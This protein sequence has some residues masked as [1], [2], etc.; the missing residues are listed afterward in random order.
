M[1][2]PPEALQE[3]IDR[4]Q[5]LDEDLRTVRRVKKSFKKLVKDYTTEVHVRRIADKCL[6]NAIQQMLTMIHARKQLIIQKEAIQILRHGLGQ[7]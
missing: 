1:A 3:V 7:P 4:I 6:I 5:Q 2:Y